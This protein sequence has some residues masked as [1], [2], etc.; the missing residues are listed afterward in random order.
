MTLPI[1]VMVEVT[2]RYETYQTKKS[3][4]VYPMP[5]GRYRYLKFSKRKLLLLDTV[6]ANDVTITKKIKI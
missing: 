3:S 4:C 2:V 1:K 6:K 5:L